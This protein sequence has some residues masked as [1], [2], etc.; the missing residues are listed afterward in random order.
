MQGRSSKPDKSPD[1]QKGKRS[2]TDLL[3]GPPPPESVLRSVQLLRHAYNMV[4]L[5]RLAPYS[6]SE[7]PAVDFGQNVVG[8][9]SLRA[10]KPRSGSDRFFDIDICMTQISAVLEKKSSNI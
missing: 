2:R 10:P 4:H 8:L 7:R 6:D 5:A 1:N 3:I 9:C